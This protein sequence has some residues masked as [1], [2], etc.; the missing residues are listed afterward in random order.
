MAGGLT[1]HHP[2]ELLTALIMESKLLES[3]ILTRI[4]T[5]TK[6]GRLGRKLLTRVILMGFVMRSIQVTVM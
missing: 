5:W 3:F 2:S 4:P 1:L 6:K